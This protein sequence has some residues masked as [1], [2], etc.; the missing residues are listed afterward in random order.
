[1]PMKPEYT[2][3]L[4]SPHAR[5]ACVDCHVGSGTSA[6]VKAKINGVHQLVEGQRR[7]RG[8]RVSE[9]EGVTTVELHLAVEWGAAAPEVASAVQSRVADYLR[10][11]AR[12]PSVT[13][14]V[15]VAGIPASG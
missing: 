7:F 14:D 10:R 5:V 9:D 2:A 1:M 8:V 6:Y 13:V 3:Y 12:L 11:T 15:V 4:H